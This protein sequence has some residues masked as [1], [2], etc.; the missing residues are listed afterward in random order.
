MVLA[1]GYRSVRACFILKRSSPAIDSEHILGRDLPPELP[2]AL[3]YFS[4][5]VTENI[6]NSRIGAPHVAMTSL[7]PCVPEPPVLL[8]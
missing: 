6:S 4:P 5:N 7:S 2:L 1:L 3:T 8:P